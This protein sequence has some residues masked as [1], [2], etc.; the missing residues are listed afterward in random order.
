MRL[1]KAKKAAKKAIKEI[2]A[3]TQAYFCHETL[4][5]QI[6]LSNLKMTYLKG[7]NWHLHSKNDNSF[8]ALRAVHI[9]QGL[10]KADM[11]LFLGQYERGLSGVAFLG[12]ACTTYT[13]GKRALVMNKYK[14]T[15]TAAVRLRDMIFIVI[16]IR[17]FVDFCS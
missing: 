11:N 16:K 6:T 15:I 2:L 14:A 17:L 3:H 10:G 9:E 13:T 12:T 7:Y 8:G 5:S 4:G 1:K